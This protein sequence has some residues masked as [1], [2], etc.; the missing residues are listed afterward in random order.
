MDMEDQTANI[1]HDFF[2]QKTGKNKT[3]HHL[4]WFKKNCRILGDKFGALT[5][6]SLSLENLLA[7]P[8]LLPK[9]ENSFHISVSKTK[10]LLPEIECRFQK[11]SKNHML[12]IFLICGLVCILKN[13]AD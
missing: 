8:T 13:P 7:F 10:V 12:G 5:W 3:I 9:S 11:L 4:E 6:S 1:G 2:I